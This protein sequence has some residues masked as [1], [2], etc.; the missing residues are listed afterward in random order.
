MKI[1]SSIVSGILL[2]GLSTAQ[3]EPGV[4]PTEIKV[5]GSGSF[6][7]VHAENSNAIKNGWE[8]YFKKINDAGG[9]HGRKIKYI[10]LDD[11]YDPKKARENAEELVNK[12]NVFAVV[13]GNGAA[14]VSAMLSLLTEKNV[15]LF[16]PFAGSAFMY[17]PLKKTV[18]AL[19]AGSDQQAQELVDYLVKTKGY[20]KFGILYQDD[21]GGSAGRDGVIKALQ[22]HNLTVARTSSHGRTETNFER[23][24]DELNKAGCDVV[25]LSTNSKQGSAF[26]KL[27]AEKRWAPAMGGVLGLSLP[28][29]QKELGKVKSAVYANEPNP[30][31]G[32]TKL[33]IIDEFMKDAAHIKDPVLLTRALYGYM[34]AKVFVEGL[35]VAGPDLT[36]AKLLTALEG[37][38]DF[39]MGGL[40]IS[41]GALDHQAFDKGFIYKLENG[42]ITETN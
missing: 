9:V 21:A 27:A 17:T 22:K 35:K 8:T 16:F 23:N 41:F 38:K 13:G 36:R 32:V 14:G 7:G 24:V 29:L 1:L 31:P 19:Q 2:M 40:K 28:V 26:I 33:S 12:Q 4:S 11:A 10:P 30:L 18:F 6:S 3:A 5:G 15:P 25:I 42:E 20:K 34:G 37:M 39:D